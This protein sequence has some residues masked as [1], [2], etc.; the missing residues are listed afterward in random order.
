MKKPIS[1][2]IDVVGSCNLSCPSFPIGNSQEVE[3]IRG[4]MAPKLLDNILKKASE[5]SEIKFIELFNWTEPLIHPKIS[6]LVEIAQSYAPCH[7]SSNL[8]LKKV[9]FDELLS[10]NPHYFRISISGFNQSTY[11]KTHRDGD[12][13]VV[14]KNMMLLAESKKRVSSNTIIE[15]LYHRYLGNLDDEIL[16]RDFAEK[17]GFSFMSVWAYMMPVRGTY[18]NTRPDQAIR[19]G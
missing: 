18:A 14:K 5:E 10:K 15:V 6:Q 16:T 7:L 1:F 12:I 11:S 4:A 13:E 19:S 17:L 2:N 3:N 8:N 9:N